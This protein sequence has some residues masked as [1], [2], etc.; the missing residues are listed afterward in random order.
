MK[1]LF[2]EPDKLRFQAVIGT[3]GIGSGMF[4]AL[5][6]NHTLG[7][8]E[9]RSGRF[10]D[11]RDYCKLHIITHYLKVLLGKEFPVI[12]V[13]KVG[14]DDVG[15]RLLVE[16]S[17]TGLDTRYVQIDPHRPTMQALCFLYPDGSGGQPDSWQTPLVVNWMQTSSRRLILPSSDIRAVGW[18]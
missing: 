11:Q 7:R 2:I 13:S 16:M 4:F 9:S 3:G 5:E 8:E 17:E 18:R 1:S 14:D 10:L 12:P 15:R 6:G